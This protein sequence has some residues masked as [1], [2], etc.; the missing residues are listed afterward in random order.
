MKKFLLLIFIVF[1]YPLMRPAYVM[2]NSSS[3]EIGPD[4]KIVRQ[5]GKAVIPLHN[6]LTQYDESA[7][8]VLARHIV[9]SKYMVQDWEITEIRETM[10]K[11]ARLCNLTAVLRSVSG[12]GKTKQEKTYRDASVIYQLVDAAMSGALSPTPRSIRIALKSKSR[13]QIEEIAGRCADY[14]TLGTLSFTLDDVPGFPSNDYLRAKA[15]AAVLDFAVALLKQDGAKN[16]SAAIKILSEFRGRLNLY[17]AAKRDMFDIPTSNIGGDSYGD[18]FLKK[19]Y[20]KRY[21]SNDDIYNCYDAGRN[22]L[23]SLPNPE[24]GKD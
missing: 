11:R 17:A 6:K 24:Q 8:G 21:A 20:G 19:K 1:A 15:C 5:S 18:R 2:A 14:I 13:G 16:Y 12:N 23:I 10:V 22:I 7:L 3:A 9:W 4:H